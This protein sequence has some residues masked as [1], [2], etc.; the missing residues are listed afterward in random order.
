MDKKYIISFI[1]FLFFFFKNVYS[2]KIDQIEIFAD[3]FTHD[4]NNKR[5]YAIGNV[6]VIDDNFKILSNE[7]IYNN[8]KKVI[9]AKKNIRILTQEGNIIRTQDFVSDNKLENAKSGKSYFYIPQINEDIFEIKYIP[10]ND[11]DKDLKT[12]KR[13]SRFASLEYERRN[14]TWEVFRSAVFSACEI[15][16]DKKKNQFDEPFIQLKANKITHDREN[17]IVEYKDAYFE[18]SGQPFFYLPYFSHPSPE[19]KR[20]SG[21]L[22][23]SYFRNVYLGDT[24]VLPY[25]YVIDDHQDITLK[26]RF[27]TNRNPLFFIQHRKNFLNGEIKN[28][29]SNTYTKSGNH[30][31]L[32]GHIES[33]G[34]FN[35]K[36]NLDLKYQ[37]HR[38]T[39]RHYLQAYK[40][41]YEDILESNLS[42]EKF[43]RNNYYSMN[44]YS[45][46]DLRSFVNNKETPTI[47]PRINL[48]LNSELKYN[49]FNNSSDFEILSL[50]REKGA[51][52]QKLFLSHSTKF[53]FLSSDGS[54][55]EIGG[56][57][58]TGIYKINNYDNPLSGVFEEDY[59]KYRFFPQLT[60]Q[61]S[62]PLYKN[63][64]KSKQIFEPKVLFVGAPNTGNDLNIPNEDSRNFDLDFPDLFNKNRLS[65]TDRFDSG[66]RVDY[67]LNYININKKKESLTSIS[68]GQSYRLRK[69]V[70]GS[71]NSGSNNYF[72]NFLG[73]IKVNPTD[74]INISSNFSI[75]P[76]NGS[77]SYAISN[78]SFGSHDTRF[79]IN[80]LL[81]SRTDGIESTTFDRRN[82]ISSGFST[83]ID[84]NWKFSA[85]TNFNLKNEIKFQNW[86]TKILYVNE[87][88]GFSLNWTRQYTYI[89]E[90]PTANYF[91][92]KFTFKEIMEGD[93]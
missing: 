52:M 16:F 11:R 1:I 9:S 30:E 57:L 14:R 3:K 53:P 15:C 71:L 32:L 41:N 56:H 27:H 88:F 48:S 28:E 70:F 51:T 34:K 84:R 74:L 69:D 44:A 49:S 92:L 77:L 78:I 36:N 4:K 17:G 58:N 76:R 7:I 42:I 61:Y 2:E 5:I 45:F 83:K 6:E 22:T 10:E 12:S 90:D 38:T 87:C 66:S 23:P 33:Y 62:K 85:S 81:V 35:F 93:L 67:G 19:V 21:F 63:T 60:F 29:I 91:E 75:V 25:Y 20:K 39:D 89:P 43:N 13:Y 82:Q 37:I 18:L 73:V 40:L 26:P 47:L 68:L 59:Y 79:N 8:D 80:H 46:Q 72:S 64:K 55:Y 50:T 31:E 24:F 54:I 86:N 65:G